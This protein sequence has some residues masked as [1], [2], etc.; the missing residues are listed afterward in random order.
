MKASP[1][2]AS[3]ATPHLDDGIIIKVPVGGPPYLPGAR[4]LA[5]LAYPPAADKKLAWRKTERA[6]CR[7]YLA[8]QEDLNDGWATQPQLVVPYHL[9]MTRIDAENRVNTARKLLDHRMG[10]A[11][12]IIPFLQVAEREGFGSR[13]GRRLTIDA[14]VHRTIE[15]E[16]ELDDWL[17]SHGMTELSAL[18]AVS[19]QFRAPRRS[20][21]PAGDSHRCGCRRCY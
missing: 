15:L 19:R 16:S 12:V 5:V 7:L 3:A 8:A 4:L 2:R 10:A 6:Y 1:A 20:G 18:P 17:R 9:M 21:K 11:Q 14:E 13:R